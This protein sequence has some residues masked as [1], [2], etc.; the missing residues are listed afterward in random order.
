VQAVRAW[1]AQEYEVERFSGILA[2]SFSNIADETNIK[3]KSKDSTLKRW[4]F[5]CLFI[6]YLILYIYQ[7]FILN[8]L[9]T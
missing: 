4:S 8:I 6:L 3:R 2:G 1:R 9:N 5:N 7:S